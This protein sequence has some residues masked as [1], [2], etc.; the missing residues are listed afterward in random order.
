VKP[1]KLVIK[2]LNSF[3]EEQ[4]IDFERLTEKGLFGIFGPTGSG[5]STILDAMTLALYGNISRDT[6]EY[7]NTLCSSLSV[8]FQF[9]I[10]VGGGRKAYIADRVVNRDKS[11]LLKLKTSRLREISE[12]ADTPIAEGS[13]E[14]KNTVETILGLTADD[15]TRSVVL[16]QGRFSEFLRLSGKDR[17]NMLERIFRL[18]KYGRSLGDRIRKTKNEKND[19]LN[20]L[21]GR[22]KSYEEQGIS[23]ERYDLLKSEMNLLTA[24]EDKLKK[25]K[26][27]LDTQFEKY[28]N[29]WQLQEELKIYRHKEQE[30]RLKLSEIE[31]K[32]QRLLRSKNALIV[33]PYVDRLDEVTRNITLNEETLVKLTQQLENI[34]KSLEQADK[35]YRYWEDKRNKDYPYLI[36]KEAN[37]NRALEL[38][39]KIKGIEEE[40][41][42]LAK[43][44]AKKKN[45]RDNMSKRLKELSDSR[46]ASIIE[47]ETSE[48]RLEHINISPEFR[49]QLQRAFKLSEDALSI[50]KDLENIVNKKKEKKRNLE[51]LIQKLDQVLNL[52]KQCYEEI[53]AGEERLKELIDNN[54][55]DSK[56]LMEKR[57]KIFNIQGTIKD[58]EQYLDKK[59]GLNKNLSKLVEEKTILERFIEDNK[60]KAAEQKILIQKLDDEIKHIERENLASLLAV[61]LKDAE[62]CPVCG[63]THHPKLAEK[64]DEDIIEDKKEAK[65]NLEEQLK[66]KEALLREKEVSYASVKGNEEYISNELSVINERLGD[67]SLEDIKREKEVLEQEFKIL[68]QKIEEW[69]RSKEYIE[70]ELIR[71]KDEK[72]SIDKN[73]AK[74]SE[75]IRA[76]KSMLEGLE[77]DALTLEKKLSLVVDELNELKGKVNIDNIKEEVKQ[78]RELDNEAVRLRNKL[79]LLGEKINKDDKERDLLTQTLSTLNVDLGKI[80]ESGIEK[81]KIIDREKL[82]INRLSD[83]KNPEEYIN[84][85]KTLKNEILEKEKKYK[86]YLE[87][88]RKEKQEINDKLVSESTNKLAL[89]QQKNQSEEKLKK[90]LIEFEFSSSKE[91]L[92]AIISQDR[93]NSIEKEI[94]EYEDKVRNIE[95]NLKAILAKLK[96]DSISEEAWISL[97]EERTEVID[98]LDKCIR[99]AAGKSQMIR[100]LEKNLLELSVLAEKKKELEHLCSN[101]DDIAKLVEGNKFVEF[102]ALNQLKYISTEASKRLKDITRGRY[103]LEIDSNGNFIMRDDFNGGARRAT[104]TLSG[105]ET[106][107]TSLSLALSLSSQIQLK[108]SAPLEFFFL[109]E[110]FGTLDNDLLETVMTSLERLH[111]EKLCVGII[112]HV[113]ELKSRVPVKLIVEPAQ[114]GISGSRVKIE[115]T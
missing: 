110:G 14:V 32:K 56:L 11:G 42:L 85:V 74:L 91:V 81:R 22:I 50:E 92:E 4:V 107:L 80:E 69:N 34:N 36:E 51:E 49:E 24:E 105:G 96:G 48:K 112:S 1:K 73:E 106:F 2:G 30:E 13:N 113:E 8:S 45:N 84:E 60:L 64:I 19:S 66:A 26:G 15:F 79:K 95:A 93:M 5:K 41:N 71:K 18:E 100:D 101:L 46:E 75:N 103:A 114:H 17:R 94:L 23:K 82:E 62:S 31:L 98:K 65:L 9:E 6:R 115:L 54:P 57:E 72:S 44:Y 10:G 29:I 90:L 77:K 25:L 88:K 97:Q 20:V 38:K 43:E 27:E 37:L 109:D 39:E 68:N 111:S 108:G 58:L 35:E 70:K 21:L 89:A 76:D 40:R 67:R 16:P 28:K 87:A 78:V 63:S 3:V 52:Q 99:D 12:E 53:Q 61:E 7:M 86:D 33:K 83:G 59:Q 47:K 55:G 104:N 102:V